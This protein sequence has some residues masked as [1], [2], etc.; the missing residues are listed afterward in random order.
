MFTKVIPTCIETSIHNCTFP[1]L[2]PHSTT[3]H[4]S[5][6]L[7]TQSTLP[8]SY[9]TVPYRTLLPAIPFCN[10][11]LCNRELLELFWSV[12]PYTSF[13]G[14]HYSGLILSLH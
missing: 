4:S 7:S 9:T 10:I 6:Y 14:T 13:Y 5:A 12:L 1:C 8:L 3:P 11:L 2:D